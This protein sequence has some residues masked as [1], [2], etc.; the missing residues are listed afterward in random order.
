MMASNLQPTTYVMNCNM[1]P[2]TLTS[3]G[4]C[5]GSGR[6]VSYVQSSTSPPPPPPDL[7]GWVMSATGNCTEGQ[8]WHW[9]C[10]KLWV[11]AEDM[12]EQNLIA[13]CTVTNGTTCANTAGNRYW[14]EPSNV[15]A[16]TYVMTCNIEPAILTSRDGCSGTGAVL[17]YVQ[18]GS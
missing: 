9:Q 15:Q 10:A 11:S 3:R 1:Q 5:S 13:T 4:G 7:S 18:S 14:M 17:S 2:S 6:E 16:E 8:S 12:A